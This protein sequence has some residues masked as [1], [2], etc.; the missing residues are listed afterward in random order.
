MFVPLSLELVGLSVL[1]LVDANVFRLTGMRVSFI[2]K[3]CC[4]S[5]HL[6]CT[7]ISFKLCV[8]GFY[9][10]NLLIIILCSA[11]DLKNVISA[12]SFLFS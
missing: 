9:I 5:V 2:R 8:C 7:V 4:D 6:H 12:V 10:F 3:K 1:S 11:G